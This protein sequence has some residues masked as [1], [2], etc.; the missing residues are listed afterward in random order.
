MNAV[1]AIERSI[2]HWK[3]IRDAFEMGT[4]VV[5]KNCVLQFFSKSHDKF[6]YR[7][8]SAEECFLCTYNDALSY[9]NEVDELDCLYCPLQK[10]GNKC[11]N[12]G[13]TWTEF[14]GLPTKANAEKMIQALEAL[15]E[16]GLRK[17]NLDNEN[18]K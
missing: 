18:Q 15:L 16:S 7:N 4:L 1:E 9:E 12:S 5:E 13:A 8:I 3:Y 17:G 10:A 6:F 14:K 11:G 2:E